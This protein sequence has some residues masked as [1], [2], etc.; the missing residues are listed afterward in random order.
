MGVNLGSVL[1]AG[2]LAGPGKSC[3]E[4][5]PGREAWIIL[6]YGPGLGLHEFRKRGQRNTFSTQPV[7][8]ALYTII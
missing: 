2:L 1:R 4:L 8:Y 6:S 7:H 3:I 5:R